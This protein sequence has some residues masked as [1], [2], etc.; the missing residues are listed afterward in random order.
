MMV[1]SSPA[2]RPTIKIRT[3]VWELRGLAKALIVFHI[4]VVTSRANQAALRILPGLV[5]S[6]IPQVPANS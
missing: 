1:I 2:Q 6:S 5:R 3:R 4:K